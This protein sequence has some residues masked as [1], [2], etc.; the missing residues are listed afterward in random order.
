L[1]LEKTNQSLGSASRKPK[2][3]RADLAPS[4]PGLSGL[5]SERCL[6][7]GQ[8]GLADQPVVSHL[9]DWISAKQI[10]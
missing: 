7:H 6:G 3:R 9:T 1:E 2:V 10:G 8:E 4:A 5:A